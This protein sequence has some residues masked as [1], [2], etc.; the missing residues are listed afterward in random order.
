MILSFAFNNRSLI[1]ATKRM[2]WQRC[3]LLDAKAQ[4]PVVHLSIFFVIVCILPKAMADF[5]AIFEESP[6]KSLYRC[7]DRYPEDALQVAIADFQNQKPGV[8]FS[9]L[10][11]YCVQQ[12]RLAPFIELLE[13]GVGPDEDL[14]ECSALKE[15]TSFLFGLLEHGWPIDHT[16]QGGRVPSLLCLVIDRPKL[17]KE[18]LQRGASPNAMSTS[19]ETPLSLAIQA[20]S[21]ATIKM[22][23]EAG[24]NVH[25]G[26][27]LHYA[28]ERQGDDLEVMRLLLS[29]NAPVNAI[30]FEHPIARRL[31]HFLLRGMPLHKACILGKYEV[32][33][34]LLR[35]GA[36]PSSTR[37]R[38]SQ[39]EQTTPL[40]IAKQQGDESMIV[41]LESY[42]QR[43][44]Y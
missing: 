17:F 2:R 3:N 18:L 9:P 40:D 23:L 8:A 44:H 34:L 42:G 41:L 30:Q 19:G 1:A 32:V 7:I 14:V 6:Y 38:G 29:C 22:L 10:L 25:E 27:V 24:A 26:D 4:K 11:H 43:S 33:D 16:L 20:G 35:H 5:S 31:R 15:N 39:I 13:A 37:M 21:P 36:N 28:V 12:E